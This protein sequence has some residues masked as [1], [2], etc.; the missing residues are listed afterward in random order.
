MNRSRVALAW[1]GVGFSLLL[2]GLAS[3]SWAQPLP[4][5]EFLFDSGSS[6]VALNTGTLGVGSSG[7][8]VGAT[9]NTD[10]PNGSAFSMGFD[11]A[12]DLVSVP[13]TFDYGSALTVEAWIKPD[14]TDGQRAIWD[15]FGPPGVVFFIN[16]LVT[17]NQIQL[18]LSTTDNPGGGIGVSG[19]EIIAVEWQHVAGVYDGAEMRVYLNG[20]LVGALANSGNILD[21][22]SLA[23]GIGAD[24]T[25]LA[26]F[27][28][29]LI[30]DVRVFDTVLTA[31]ELA[32][33]AF[34]DPI[35]E[36]SSALL[37]GMGCLGLVALA[38]KQRR[39]CS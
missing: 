12:N 13:D 19:G 4:I 14:A 9:P 1:R 21:N 37:L 29:G 34:A 8:V 27:F 16:S 11:G 33:G 15:D 7:A 38:R 23:A 18:H 5:L 3:T 24:N 39:S 35:P 36:P 22:G 17:P 32:N 25:G 20:A 26:V 28:D 30:D 10:T 6:T 2:W 31:D